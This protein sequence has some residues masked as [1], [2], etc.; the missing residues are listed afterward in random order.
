LAG[1]RIDSFSRLTEAMK[2]TPAHYFSGLYALALLVSCNE[3]SSSQKP[4]K[5]AI[6][7][8]IHPDS[9]D[10]PDA[11]INC[12]FLNMPGNLTSVMQIAG[13]EEPGER[14]VISGTLF[15]ADSETPY[16]DVILYAY[17][18]DQAGY[19]SKTGK[20]T[21]VQK[22][23]GH[24]HGWAKTDR[25]GRYE[26]RSIRPARYPGNTIPAHIHVAVKTGNKQ[27]YYVSDFVFKDDSLVNSPYISSVRD[28]PGGTGVVDLKNTGK[29]S[30][31]G[32][33]DIFLKD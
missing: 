33:R 19:Y 6:T 27:P 24:L 22:W 5:T 21:G 8:H 15:K 32:K 16:P 31:A 30:W 4:P 12:N 26:I 23:H 2:I 3:P 13:K 11:D 9:C 7:K 17:H 10:N 25:N 29:D 18:T 20:E 14:L 28:L 1:Y